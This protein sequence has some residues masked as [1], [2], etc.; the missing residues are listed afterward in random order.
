MGSLTWKGGPG[1]RSDPS[2]W[3]VISGADTFP[4]AGDD[5]TIDAPTN[6]V[7]SMDGSQEAANI[8]LDGAGAQLVVSGTLALGGTL[9]AQAGTFM[10]DDAVLR[11]GTYDIAGGSATVTGGTLDGVTWQGILAT[12]G[13]VAIVHGL[14]LAGA[15]GSGT[16]TLLVDAIAFA[17]ATA[18]LD[19]AR[20]VMTGA[21]HIDVAGAG[22]LTLGGD[23]SLQMTPD[24]ANAPT[25]G[26]GDDTVLNL[27][28]ILPAKFGFAG[29]AIIDGDLINENSIDVTGGLDAF[30]SVS[31]TLVNDGVITI[32]GSGGPAAAKLVNNGTIAFQSPG[33]GGNGVISVSG[34]YSGTGAVLFDSAS[35]NGG[36][37]LVAGTI[38]AGARLI[39]GQGSLLIEAAAIDP[40]A[41]IENF[42]SGDILILGN[43]PFNGNVNAF[44]D[45]TP[46]GGTLTIK[47]ADTVKATLHL[48]GIASGAAFSV[49]AAAPGGLLIETDNPA[50]CFAAGTRIR[51]ERGEKP[52]EDLRAGDRVVS[53]FGGTVPVVW[54][55]SRQVRTARH[56]DPASVLPIRVRAGALGEGV[57]AR[58]VLLSPE[59]AIYAD[60]L[61]V[62]AGL[63]VNGR[64]IVREWRAFVTYFHVELPQHDVILAEGAPC[65]SYLDTGNRMDFDNGGP[66]VAAHPAFSGDTASEIWLANACAPQ[67][68]A[69]ARLDALREVLAVRAGSPEAGMGREPV[70]VVRGGAAGWRRS[71]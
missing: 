49:G 35:H 13:T 53:A 60:G 52:V 68:R 14:A 46:A 48:S 11:G 56:R 16:G 69:G 12:A 55:G 36:M 58:D 18:T 31:G 43:V 9:L 10:A 30:F 32:N 3:T 70:S 23:A 41:T 34:D 39:H 29:R 71:G 6:Y 7:V 62:P 67:C 26:D 47:D 66:A 20:I 25:I 61:L 28:T 64:S 38:G 45:G 54:I 4:A 19:N 1:L 65:E 42:S 2:K 22:T 37:L 8:T 27:G 21:R 44:Y 5:A 17:E 57:P 40:T 33:G 63:L 24:G 59:H 51:V 15:N 50:P